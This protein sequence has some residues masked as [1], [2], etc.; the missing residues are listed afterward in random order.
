MSE[1]RLN[2]KLVDL[3]FTFD[4]TRP[5]PNRFSADPNDPTRPNPSQHAPNRPMPPDQVV[6]LIRTGNLNYASFIQDCRVAGGARRESTQCIPARSEHRFFLNEEESGIGGVVAQEPYAAVLSCIDARV[7]VELITGQAANDTFVIRTA[8]N[9]LTG[10]G[11]GSGSLRY[12]LSNYGA[13]SG[14]E[15]STV[16]AIFVF[17]HTKCGAVKAAYDAFKSNGTG[18]S[19]VHKSLANILLEIKHA[20]DFV[21]GYA[22]ERL[23]DEEEIKNAI[24]HVNAVFTSI[25]ARQ[26]AVELGVDK[27]I[28][29]HFASYH[30]TDFYLRKTSFPKQPN[31]NL[32]EIIAKKGLAESLAWDSG[33]GLRDRDAKEALFEDAIEFAKKQ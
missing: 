8:G 19:G 32:V 9:T 22:S 1:N 31:H 15:H 26:I 14:G 11:E 5:N 20:V 24:S 10:D 23:K 4:G 27:S 6:E 25:R 18:V 12:I 16:S 29:V 28:E 21:L 17:G 3:T 13:G 33:Q 7:P 2:N 30:V